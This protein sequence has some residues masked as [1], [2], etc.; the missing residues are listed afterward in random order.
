MVIQNTEDQGQN[1]EEPQSEEIQSEETPVVE[2]V[3]EEQQ[4]PLAETDASEEVVEDSSATVDSVEA[5][6][7]S[8]IEPVEGPTI[9]D[10]EEEPLTK[11]Q[12]E[13]IHGGPIP[14]EGSGQ[15]RTEMIQEQAEQNIEA[16]L[17]KVKQEQKELQDFAKSSNWRTSLMKKTSEVA[18]SIGKELSEPPTADPM[19]FFFGVAHATGEEYGE[20]MIN[21]G[22]DIVNPLLEE[23]T[24]TIKK[25]GEPMGFEPEGNIRI[26]YFH[27]EN[28]GLSYEPPEDRGTLGTIGHE[29]SKGILHAFAPLGWYGKAANLG[30]KAPNALIRGGGKVAS[31]LGKNTGKVLEKVSPNGLAYLGKKAVNTTEKG[32]DLLLTIGGNAAKVGEKFLGNPVKGAKI[33]FKIDMLRDASETGTIFDM[34]PKDMVAEFMQTDNP[35]RT[36]IEGR[37]TQALEG[38]IFGAALSPVLKVGGVTRD[39]I[40][41]SNAYKRTKAI[42]IKNVAVR[43][44]AQVALRQLFRNPNLTQ[45]QIKDGIDAIHKRTVTGFED[46]DKST[47]K[48][49]KEVEDIGVKKQKARKKKEIEDRKAKDKAADEE[50]VKNIGIVRQRGTDSTKVTLDDVGSEAA[51]VVPRAVNKNQPHTMSVNDYLLSFSKEEIEE[52]GGREALL[53]L[54]KESVEQA[55]ND[56]QA[57]R[58]GVIQ[59]YPAL[60]E[61]FKDLYDI[62]DGSDILERVRIKDNASK[63]KNKDFHLHKL[64]KNLG[65][66]IVDENGVKLNR[67]TIEE[68]ILDMYPSSAAAKGQGRR[69]SESKPGSKVNAVW[70][71]TDDPGLQQMLRD[72]IDDPEVKRMLDNV[73]KES[74]AELKLFLDDHFESRGMLDVSGANKI[75]KDASNLKKQ[76]LLLNATVT[77]KLE[78]IKDLGDELVEMTQKKSGASDEQ[79]QDKLL[80]IQKA[81]SELWETYAA[82]EQANSEIGSTLQLIQMNKS[83][84]PYVGNQAVGDSLKT[85]EDMK[86]FLTAFGG[87]DYEKGLA[88]YTKDSLRS[89]LLND[90]VGVLKSTPSYNALF[91]NVMAQDIINSMLSSPKSAFVNFASPAAAIAVDII[92]QTGGALVR[93]PIKAVRGALGGGKKDFEIAGNELSEAFI[94]LKSHMQMAIA[95]PRALKTAWKTMR[96]NRSSFDSTGS[97]LNDGMKL[98][99][100]I[101]ARAGFGAGDKNIVTG[102]AD[103][104][105]L[106][107]S[108][109]TRFLAATDDFWKSMIYQQSSMNNLELNLRSTLL[110]TTEENLNRIRLARQSGKR[111]PYNKLSEQELLVVARKEA[112][113][114]VLKGRSIGQELARL[115]KTIL[116]VDG[117]YTYDKIAE[118]AVKNAEEAAE[119]GT[120]AATLEDKRN[121][122]KGFMHDNY[123]L[124][125]VKTSQQALKQSQ[126]LTF[127]SPLEDPGRSAFTQYVGRLN[128]SI[129]TSNIFGPV[130]RTQLP[131]VQTPYNIISYMT[132]RNPVYAAP[133]ALKQM[134]KDFADDLRLVDGSPQDALKARN[135]YGRAMLAIGM[136]HMAWNDAFNGKV[137]GTPPPNPLAARQEKAMG[138]MPYSW[139]QENED[140]T[141]TYTDMRRGAP[142]TSPWIQAANMKEWIESSQNW[143]EE[144]TFQFVTEL[145]K[146]Q[147]LGMAE[148]LKEHPMLQGSNQMYKFITGDGEGKA[149]ILRNMSRNVVPYSGFIKSFKSDVIQREQQNIID[150]FQSVMPGNEGGDGLAKR[151][152]WGKQVS[153]FDEAT[154]HWTGDLVQAAWNMTNPFSGLTP[155]DDPLFNEYTRL[156]RAGGIKGFPGERGVKPEPFLKPMSSV[157]N[158]G[159]IPINLK[160]FKDIP[161]TE[162]VTLIEDGKKVTKTVTNNGTA[163]HL[164]MQRLETYEMPVTVTTPQKSANGKVLRNVK[165]EQVNMTLEESLKYTLVQENVRVSRDENGKVVTDKNGNAVYEIYKPYD[166]LDDWHAGFGTGVKDQPNSKSVLW[167][168]K[169]DAYRKAV[170]ASFVEEFLTSD[171]V[172]LQKMGTYFWLETN[173][174]ISFLKGDKQ[175]ARQMAKWIDEISS[176][177]YTKNAKKLQLKIHSEA[178]KIAE[179]LQ[180]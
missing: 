77:R 48:Y 109:S 61:E 16:G 130:V 22:I 101:S 119:A 8:A 137:T 37:L 81:R 110:K 2:T 148:A 133:A 88:M 15:A 89:L 69:R 147:I 135:A 143:M 93:A 176:P 142:F 74:P 179:E 54:H 94:N 145:M 156:L 175:K 97:K 90:A 127:T 55:L 87:G 118:L 150:A 98:D 60:R 121:Y 62:I 102:F 27:L 106:L 19:D 172:D 25:I 151:I 149:Q 38:L 82:A 72:I 136:T 65:I 80:E 86:E 159:G 30:L 5:S 158:V 57:V 146:I 43:V 154:K 78:N 161:I 114:T 11:E 132:K 100:S 26:P 35:D 59:N 144:D 3:T 126:K 1:P 177:A 113:E 164:I 120:I 178:A 46:I 124:G 9:D 96:N 36:F 50:F 165:K 66:S 68:K 56:G 76:V 122:I 20:F 112:E 29:V 170:R 84:R 163:W 47:K 70:H 111:N 49:L 6:G 31:S 13:E 10:P 73:D 40:V 63:S 91:S 171:N 18:E 95:I 85:R 139:V 155:P 116:Q 107:N 83:T 71:Y 64:A 42:Y 39:A 21:T 34:L 41:N 140:G 99:E 52:I 33:G 108:G 168:T 92:E 7:N 23:L 12:M 58:P 4:A 117:D 115:H 103:F 53:R 157:L 67:G 180:R 134:Y 44:Q 173:A 125:L 17:E 105:G 129:D 14:V 123:D 128:K 167:I 162:E 131:F 28:Y 160:K 79:I 45:K 141:K 104:F 174:K 166:E 75:A 32:Y 152:I 51:Q 138:R 24:P 169:V 153:R